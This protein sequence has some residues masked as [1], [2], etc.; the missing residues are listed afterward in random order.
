MPRKWPKFSDELRAALRHAGLTQQQLADQI[1]DALGTDP[2]QQVVSNWCSGKNVP[3]DRQTFLAL[4]QVLHRTGGMDS[5][6]AINR[7]LRSADQGA[8]HPEEIGE[9]LPGLA[10]NREQDA[11]DAQS[12]PSHA[13]LPAPADDVSLEAW[14]Q[15]FIERV[16]QALRVFE[17]VEVRQAAG[18]II[19]ATLLLTVTWRSPAQWRQRWMEAG[20]LLWAQWASDLLLAWPP[21]R[22]ERESAGKERRWLK[23]YRLS[24]T[25]AGVMV[26]VGGMFFASAFIQVIFGHAPARW[27]AFLILGAGAI[28]AYGGGLKVQAGASRV[29]EQTFYRR[30]SSQITLFI[31]IAQALLPWFFVAASDFIATGYLAVIAVALVLLWPVLR[32]PS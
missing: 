1:S 5:L 14:A 13:D 21:S 4:C 22:A 12:G 23:L 7:L 11:K 24:G 2:S 30:A 15:Q 17:R 9:W 28:F 27:L 26:A 10:Q 16:G 19:L 25:A 31:F 3:G 32:R 8:L 18:V 20:L 6:E 29:E